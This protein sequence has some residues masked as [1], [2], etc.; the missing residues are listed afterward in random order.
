MTKDPAPRLSIGFILA[1]R[2]TLCAFANFVVLASPRA[3]GGRSRPVRC[4]WQVC[5]PHGAVTLLLRGF[6]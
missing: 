3:R 5:R 6:P 2:F 4:R 1:E